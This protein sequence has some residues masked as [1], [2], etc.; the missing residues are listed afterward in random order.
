M[1]RS[2]QNPIQAKRKNTPMNTVRITRLAQIVTA[3]AVATI[4]L[5]ATAHA[6]ADY[7]QFQSPS[8]DIRCLING[9]DAPAP[10]AMCQ[11]RDFTYAV[12]PGLPKDQ[13]GGPCPPGSAL[14]RDFRLDQGTSGYMTCTYSALASGFGDWPTLDYGQSRSFGAIT[15]DSETSG[16]TCTDTST[17]HFLEV[18]RESYQVG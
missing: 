14:G 18:S 8:G 15:C 7:Q 10:I 1:A 13:N 4:A 5:P 12:P 11:I 3:T 17:G 6:D 9:R 16:V 2:R